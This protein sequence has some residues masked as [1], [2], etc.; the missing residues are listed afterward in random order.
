MEENKYIV[1]FFTQYGAINY[2]KLLKKTGIENTT[3]PVPRSLSSSCGICIET[4]TE[5]DMLQFLTEDVEGVYL[6]NEGGYELL[7]QSEE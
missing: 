6:V 4:S 5:K 1:L 7:Y 3:R 2:S